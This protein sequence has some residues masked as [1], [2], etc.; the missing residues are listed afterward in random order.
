MQHAEPHH[1]FE[2]F[3][4]G[5]TGRNV[6]NEGVRESPQETAALR[7]DG[8]GGDRR[9]GARGKLNWWFSSGGWPGPQETVDNVWTHS[10]CRK[11]GRL[12]LALRG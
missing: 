5:Y 12:L 3:P 6:R 10:G 4:E 7:E 2:A 11:L 1:P 8:D 9:G